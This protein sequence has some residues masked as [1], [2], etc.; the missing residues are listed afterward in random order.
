[1]NIPHILQS[2]VL[3]I[4]MN[5]YETMLLHRLYYFML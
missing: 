4:Q 3:R 2:H 5:P 1:V